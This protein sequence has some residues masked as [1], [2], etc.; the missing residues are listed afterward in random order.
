M[1]FFYIICF[2]FLS[3]INTVIANNNIIFIDMDKVILTS[4]VGSSMMKQL[5]KIN[6]DNLKK[7]KDNEK[8]FKDKEKKLV[9]QKNILTEEKFKISLNE[10]RL[11]VNE[12]NKDRNTIIVNFN[13]LKNNNTNKLL[14]LINP[15]LAE[16]AKD[17]SIA[18]I[19]KKKNLIMGIT[20]LDIT[21]KIIKI[22]DKNIKEFKVN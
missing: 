1:K 5:N 20:E 18:I 19:L 4:K 11:E 6:N 7:F 2:I 12:Y 10:L 16:Y 14:K 17:N 15:I 8:I 3:L 9:N 22:V 21:D 13:K